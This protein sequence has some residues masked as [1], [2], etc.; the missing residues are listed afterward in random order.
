MIIIVST[1]DEDDSI[2]LVLPGYRE[3]PTKTWYRLIPGV[4]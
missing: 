4:C 3:Y 2:K 1:K